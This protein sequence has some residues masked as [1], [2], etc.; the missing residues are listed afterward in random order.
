MKL[1]PIPFIEKIFRVDISDILPKD[2]R[3]R[4]NYK[5]FSSVKR[6]ALILVPAYCVITHTSQE[7]TS[8]KVVI[9]LKRPNE[10]D[11]I[12]VVYVP[13]L[14]VKRLAD[15]VILRHFDYEVLLIKTSKSQVGEMERLDKLDLDTHSRFAEWF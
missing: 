10:T 1:V 11:D 3:T 14:R 13:L 4:S 2:K 8:S 7:Q 9:D 6:R 5:A 15:L 12:I